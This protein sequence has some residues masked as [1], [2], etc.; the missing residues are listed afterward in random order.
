LLMMGVK[1]QSVRILKYFSVS[2]I[3]DLKYLLR[4]FSDFTAV[5]LDKVLQM[6]SE[7]L[8]ILFS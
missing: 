1:R 5:N 7:V 6:L 2:R 8:I 3:Y 4:K